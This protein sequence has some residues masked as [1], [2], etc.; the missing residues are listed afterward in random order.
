[1]MLLIVTIKG[2][3]NIMPHYPS[4]GRCQG[5]GEF[6]NYAKFKCTT[7]RHAVQSN[8]NLLLT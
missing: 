3:I 2:T 7:Y 1:M 8:P 4:P 5:K 6:L